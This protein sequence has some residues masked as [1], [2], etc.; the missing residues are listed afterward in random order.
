M[1]AAP[2]CCADWLFAVAGLVGSVVVSVRWLWKLLECVATRVARACRTATRSLCCFPSKVP[3]LSAVISPSSPLSPSSI[4]LMGDARKRVSASFVDSM[5]RCCLM[6]GSRFG[7]FPYSKSSF[8]PYFFGIFSISIKEE[9][10]GR[11]SCCARMNIF[12]VVMGSNH[13]L[14]QPQTTGKNEGAPMTFEGSY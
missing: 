3:T 5:L 7:I 8:P 11:T 4:H 6:F 1:K 13:F 12:E 14:T 9:R 10:V 2:P